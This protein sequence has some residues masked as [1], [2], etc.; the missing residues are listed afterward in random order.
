[1][2]SETDFQYKDGQQTHG[3]RGTVIP[4]AKLE[5]GNRSQLGATFDMHMA[6]PQNIVDVEIGPDGVEHETVRRLN[7]AALTNLKSA[8]SARVGKTVTYDQAISESGKKEPSAPLVNLTE[9]ELLPAQAAVRPAE[10]RLTNSVKTLVRFTGNFGS[11]RIGYDQV[12]I[13]KGNFLLLV[14]VSRGDTSY[15]APSN[16]DGHIKIEVG[17]KLYWSPVSFQY[18]MPE[19]ATHTIFVIDED[20]NPDREAS[21]GE[22]K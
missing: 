12:F 13:H 6:V 14:L 4:R 19:G 3:M 7:D 16:V 10:V 17:G 21:D 18:I 20:H 11:L 9:G 1:M 5:P 2:A 22:E 8:N 15:E